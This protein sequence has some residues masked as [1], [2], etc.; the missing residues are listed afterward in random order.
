[1][2]SGSTNPD[3]VITN[4]NGEEGETKEILVPHLLD[5]DPFTAEDEGK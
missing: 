2:D 3:E 1:M 4:N 5:P